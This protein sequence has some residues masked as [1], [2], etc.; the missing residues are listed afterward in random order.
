MQFFLKAGHRI[1]AILYGVAFFSAVTTCALTPGW[2]GDAQGFTDSKNICLLSLMCSAAGP[3]LHLG[4]SSSC[5][6]DQI[7]VTRMPNHI[8]INVEHEGGN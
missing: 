6:R 2:F 3:L 1:C 4:N 8:T 7:A 5:V